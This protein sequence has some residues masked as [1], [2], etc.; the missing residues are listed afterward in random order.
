AA[1]PNPAW[2]SSEGIVG[3]KLF[4]FH[5]WPYVHVENVDSEMVQGLAAVLTRN[6]TTTPQMRE[7]VEGYLA[8]QFNAVIDLATSN[9]SNIYAGSW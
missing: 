9:G 6:S 4:D 1:I 7:Y 3:G 5:S 8:V 2:Q